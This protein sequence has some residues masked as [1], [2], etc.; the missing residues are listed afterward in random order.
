MEGY[1]SDFDVYYENRV[2]GINFYEYEEKSYISVKDI[3]MYLAAYIKPID[4]KYR[5]TKKIVDD[6]CKENI[7]SA[8]KLSA[9]AK[10]ERVFVDNHCKLFITNLDYKCKE[11]EHEDYDII[12]YKISEI[13]KIYHT[14]KKSACGRSNDEGLRFSLFAHYGESSGPTTT[15]FF[16]PQYNNPATAP[17]RHCRGIT[18]AMRRSAWG[19]ARGNGRA[20]T[21]LPNVCPTAA[22]RPAGR[23]TD[24][25]RPTTRHFK[26]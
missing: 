1:N 12:D 10:I 21:L 15:P 8:D 5:T 4:C 25:Y 20:P 17:Q 26:T 13:D 9:L 23:P 19:R 7:S 3:I 11:Y 16:F 6:Y 24:A 14:P 2:D 18:P 22:D